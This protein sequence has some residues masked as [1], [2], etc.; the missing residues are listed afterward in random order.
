MADKDL[1]IYA[2][3]LGGLGN[4]LFQYTTARNLADRHCVELVVV[5]DW[6]ASKANQQNHLTPRPF[7]LKHFRRVRYS[8]VVRGPAHVFD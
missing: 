1:R 6:L 8:M 4:Q 3:L 5:T 2:R 7:A